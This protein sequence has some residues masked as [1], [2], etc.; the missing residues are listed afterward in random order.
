MLA[1]LHAA[2]EMPE[3]DGPRLV[4]AAWLEA[5]GDAVRAEFLRRQR[6]RAPGS[7]WDRERRASTRQRVQELLAHYGGGWPFPGELLLARFGE[8]PASPCLRTFTFRWAPGMGRRTDARPILD[9]PEDFFGQLI[10]LPLCQQLT[11]LG[12][13]FA[14][15][16]GQAAVLRVAG[17]A[18]ILALPPHRPHT[19]PPDTFRR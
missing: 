15:A 12:S 3:D 5:H 7:S 10:R 1:L 4:R 11:Q 18:P 19:L 17:V 16:E 9:L 8:A 14:F 2:Q 6:F 13:S